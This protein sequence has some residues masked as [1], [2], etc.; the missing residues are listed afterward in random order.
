MSKK[1]ILAI[2]TT[3]L[4]AL[5]FIYIVTLY[6]EKVFIKDEYPRPACA[7]YNEQKRII[8]VFGNCTLP[9]IDKALKDDQI[10]RR[11]SSDRIWLLNS[12]IVVSKGALLTINDTQAKWIK[13]DSGGKSVLSSEGKSS[14]EIDDTSPYFIQ[15]FG[16][17]DLR[18]VKITSWDSFK[19]DYS[20]Q[21]T[22]G[23]LPRPYIT[24]ASGAGPSNISDSE[25]AYLGFN[26][27]RKQGLTFHGGDSSKLTENKIHD[28]WF[29][30]FSTSVGHMILENN[31]VFDNQRYGLDPHKRSHDMTFKGNYLYNNRVGLICSFECSNIL[32]E[33]NKVEKNNAI[34]LMFSRSSVNST[35]R[36]NNVSDSEV[37]VAISESHGNNVF[38]NL[39]SGSNK[40]ISVTNN[41]TDNYLT[42]NTI[43]SPTD[44]GI[45]V[46]TGSKN[47]KFESNFIQNFSRSGICVSGNAD[48]NRFHSNEIEGY[49]LYGIYVKDQGS[50][51]TFHSNSIHF[52]NHAISV[53]GNNKTFFIDNK[54]GN[55][56]GHQY[57]LSG[58][59]ILNLE[60]THF[61]GDTIR[62]AGITSNFAKIAKSG[63]IDIITKS[64]G[65]DTFQR[66]R[67]DTSL[68]PYVIKL[69]STTLKLYSK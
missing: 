20:Y 36:Y 65:S 22:N 54:I 56:F 41:S 12:S 26:S 51:N 8:I 68:D 9:Q 7:T 15:V 62:S 47:N 19:D 30:F 64:P 50:G 11:E 66:H 4:A 17:L 6:T 21:N 43:V 67:Y 35:I 33:N 58:N 42:N 3:F 16:R 10:L 24:I 23:S 61:L 52:A 18:G 34:G 1:Q 25:I 14:I 44:C 27:S 31:S 69:N 57:I 45:R 53:Y 59:A 55:T 49:G 5:I 63:I 39:I 60:D 48:S 40:G 13:I 29:G 38:E 37:G 46:S 28:L 32:F 2:V